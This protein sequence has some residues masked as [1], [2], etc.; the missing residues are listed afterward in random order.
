[1]IVFLCTYKIG[2]DHLR[3]FVHRKILRPKNV[4]R[5]TRSLMKESTPH[6]ML[7]RKRIGILMKNSILI[8]LW[9]SNCRAVRAVDDER[10]RLLPK[11]R[12]FLVHGTDNQKPECVQIHPKES[13]TCPGNRLCWHILVVRLSIG[14]NDMRPKRNPNITLLRNDAW[15]KT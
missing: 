1:M 10:V 12:R 6:S 14:K 15:E 7:G 9:D 13:C 8:R 3:Y 11:N 2:P 5:R 4:A